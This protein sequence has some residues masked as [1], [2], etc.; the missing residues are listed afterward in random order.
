MSKMVG[1]ACS[2]K[3]NWLNTAVQLLADKLDED[4]YKKAI[5]EYLS[6][7]IDSPTRLRKTREI[8]M[9]AW[10]YSD[11][12][13]LMKEEG[14]ALISKYPDYA[15]P[16]HLCM[17]C[18][19]YPVFACVCKYMGKLFNFQD[20]VTNA[21]LKQKLYDEWGERSTLETTSRRVTLTLK[22]LGLI[23]ADSGIRYQANY[24]TISC[25][26]IINFMTLIAMQ[27]EKR[28]YYSFDDIGKFDIYFPF[29]Y[30]LNKEQILNDNRFITTNFNGTLSVTKKEN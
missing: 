17:L 14:R 15:V 29:K 8:L 21:Q 20:E 28:S 25:S 16:I 7:E 27:I 18:N 9:H 11:D 6:F 1:F 4:S 24:M 13:G 30:S 22:E 19:A 2:L 23:K 5:N 10:Y 26:P 3:L 12:N